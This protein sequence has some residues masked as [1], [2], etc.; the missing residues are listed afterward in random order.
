MARLFVICG[1]GDG[2]PGACAGGETE[3]AN[4]RELAAALKEAGGPAVTVLDV[5]KD[6][7]KECCRDAHGYNTALKAMAGGDPVV[8]LHQDDAGA[9]ARGG[10]V[11]IAEGLEADAYDEAMADAIAGLFPGRADKL[12][13]RGN[14]KTVNRAKAYGINYRLLECCFISDEGDRVRFHDQMPQLVAAILGAF[15]IGGAPADQ[16]ARPSAGNSSPGKPSAPSG[17][18]EETVYSFPLVKR[19]ANGDAV[20][21]MQAALNLRSAAGLSVDG[22]Y[23]DK[24]GRALVAW[25]RR[26]GVEADGD[27]GPIT[28]G[29]L[30][31]G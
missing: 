2:D 17:G 4:V 3:A 24:T 25:Q 21:M 11:I 18:R 5:A 30:L 20:R 26:C 23:G 31:C 8:E 14:I 10:H 27:C 1:H 12:A 22:A 13:H 19:G 6:P 9:G 15:G 16:P 7:Y 28:W 29:T